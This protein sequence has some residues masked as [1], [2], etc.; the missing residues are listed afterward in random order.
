MAEVGTRS[1]RLV[2]PATALACISDER[3]FHPFRASAQY[4]DGSPIY[5]Y[6]PGSP[7]S[8]AISLSSIGAW[9]MNEEGLTVWWF[10]VGNQRELLVMER[11]FFADEIQSLLPSR[12]TISR[13]DS[14]LTLESYCGAN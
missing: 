7:Q 3:V 13:K 8:E 4:A 1:F 11:S 12:I 5:R 10:G 9:S 2:I 14:L 6:G